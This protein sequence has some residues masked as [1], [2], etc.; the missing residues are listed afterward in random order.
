MCD[1][2]DVAAGI[3]TALQDGQTGRRYILGGPNL[4]YFEM[5]KLFAAVSG[6]NAPI[7]RVGPLLGRAAGCF[8]DLATKLT[9]REP[10]VNS[11]AVGMSNSYHYYTSARAEQELGYASRDPEESAQDA[12]AWFQAN[13]YA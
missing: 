3:V 13:G 9:G 7:L 5:W 8:G 10:D 1:V 6:G 4:T 12:W 2:R 11:A